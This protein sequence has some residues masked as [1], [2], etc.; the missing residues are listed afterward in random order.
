MTTL[1]RDVLHDELDTIAVPPGDLAGIRRRGRRI[2][3]TR[4]A[5]VGGAA[6]LVA[7]L[8]VGLTQ[9]SGSAPNDRGVQ[10]IGKLDYSHGLR[11]YADPGAE[12]HLG[13]RTFPAG[14]LGNLDVEG[15]ATPYGVVFYDRGVPSLLDE[16]GRIVAG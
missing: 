8:V 15:A 16:S 13:G 3:G 4:W 10:P 1:L 5:A 6:V 14:R 2:R 9:L 11:A 7:G 12:I